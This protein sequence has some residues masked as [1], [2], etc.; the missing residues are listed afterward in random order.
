ML[1][2]VMVEEDF[3]RAGAEQLWRSRK[4]LEH[5]LHLAAELGKTLLE[6]NHELEQGLQEMYTTNHE[7]LQEIEYLNKQVDLLR[8][9][10]DHHVKVY[11]HL[12]V[13]SR[14]L[15]KNNHSLR[16]ENRAAQGKIQSLT[17]TIDGLQ[18]HMEV[19][20]RQVEELKVV[21]AQCSRRERVEARWSLAAHSVSCLKELY[22]LHEEAA[23]T[24]ESREERSWPGL[25]H[26]QLAEEKSCL[27]DTLRSLQVQLAAERKL[28]EASEH[29][30]EET[31]QEKQDLE[32]RLA[33]L[34]RSERRQAEL[35][36]EV[37]ELRQLW[38][39][40]SLRARGA[41]AL[42][43][44]AVFFPS[45]EEEEPEEEDEEEPE[46]L[47]RGH[48]WAE[49]LRRGHERTCARR[50]TRAG[51]RRGVSLLSEVDAQY[52]ALQAQY[53][54]LLQRSRR[55]HDALSH[56]AVQTPA[57][58]AC[59]RPH[60]STHELY[61]PE[62]KALFEEIFTCIQKTKE[63]LRENSVGVC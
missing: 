23:L 37:D 62:Y 58:H 9:M 49:E 38:R 20:Q 43:L 29:V 34:Q 57:A 3:D 56:K 48:V 47:P 61:Q 15:E 19:L 12:D 1:A 28:R 21:Q 26:A 6:R 16:L 11:E 51:S 8:Q 14:D 59:T 42:L 60:G 30:T 44:G 55:S 53:E 5:D 24:S 4:D 17:E 18:A 13:A 45:E 50:A 40:E 32:R 41:D 36:A 35:E 33:Q 2:G 63:D 10:N 27:W 31:E 52:S 39:S 54:E 25:D 46:R 7:Q 22:D